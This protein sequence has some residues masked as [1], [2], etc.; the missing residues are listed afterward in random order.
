MRRL[1]FV[2]AICAAVALMAGPALAQVKVVPPIS[3][4]P[5]IVQGIISAIDLG[6]GSVTLVSPTAP[7]APAPTTSFVFFVNAQTI[8][9]KNGRPAQLK[10]LA[11]GDICGARVQLSST[12]A[13]AI[14]VEAKSPL[15]PGPPPSV[16]LQGMIQAIDLDKSTVTLGPPA[17]PAGSTVPTPAPVT[18]LVVDTT[19]IY[20]NGQPAL[21]KDLAVGDMAGVEAKRATDGT[22]TAVC[23]Q[24]RPPVVPPPPQLKTVVGVISAID[25][26]A[27]TFSLTVKPGPTAPPVVLKF[28]AN[29]DTKIRKNGADAT[30][31]DLKVNDLAAVA[32]VVTPTMTPTST[33]TAVAID[34]KT[35]SAPPPPPKVTLTGIIS[36]IDLD[37][38][39]ITLGPPAPPIGSTA[40][41]PAP[42]TIFVV[43]TTKIVKNGQPALFKDL[44]VGDA[45]C[46]QAQPAADGTLTALAIDA[47][48]PV[49]PPPPP[50]KL[51]IVMGVISA[52]D[53]SALTFSLTVRPSA[54]GAPVVLKFI[55]DANTKIHK[56]GKDAVFGD[57]KVG[58][59]AGVGFMADPA[60][61]PAST[62]L[63]V[64]IEAK[65]P[66]TVPPPPPATP[67]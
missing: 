55:V 23:I 57:L 48:S 4:S 26:A 52:I 11:I 1:M 8:I 36:A 65:T 41:T 38:G 19:K 59:C 28:I 13:M 67:R 60:I 16:F 14:V 37:K 21:L 24:A 53:T 32:F 49:I 42:V 7:G 46:V 44:A 58:D 63:A 25:P 20:R 2:S 3:T 56:D 34:A 66:P 61:T 64:A 54:T 17:P 50:P 30:F 51:K 43:A 29:A 35:P 62:I 22:L 33:M 27:L 10:D 45:A 15:P 18:I 5:T 31:G 9:N 39:T 12:G 40:P 6:K 47:R